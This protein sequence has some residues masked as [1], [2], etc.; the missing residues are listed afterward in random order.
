[1]KKQKRALWTQSVF[2]G[3]FLIGVAL[4]LLLDNAQIL[5]I[6]PQIGLWQ[7]LLGVALLA[8]IIERLVRG[9]IPQIFFVF[10]L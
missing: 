3:L 7:I 1:M 8:I 10:P 4:V 6:G 5:V 2:W 9:K